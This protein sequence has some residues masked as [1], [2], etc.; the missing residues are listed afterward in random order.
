[1]NAVR[2]AAE[3]YI[4]FGW[5][6]IE[7]VGPLEGG[8]RPRAREWQNQPQV[9]PETW[10]DDSNIGLVTGEASGVVVIDVDGPAG[11]DSLEA[12]QAQIG[13]LPDGPYQ[14]TGSGGAHLLYRYGPECAHLNN[15]GGFRPGLDFRTTG[16]QV[17]LAPSVHASGSAYVMCDLDKELP[18]LPAA[19]IQE[20]S[21]THRT[22]GESGN[23]LTPYQRETMDFA[24]WL[25][26]QPGTITGEAGG[27]EM[28][29]IARVAVR[30]ALLQ[31]AAKFADII[32]GS[33]WNKKKCFPPWTDRWELEKRFH[34]A[35]ARWQADGVVP[36]P[37]DKK[38]HRYKTHMDLRRIVREDPIFA[39][40]LRL[41]ELGG[42]KEYDGQALTDAS[43][44][45][46]RTLIC[47]RYGYGDLDAT[48]VH[49]VVIE[50]CEVNRY[51]PVA[52]Y[53]EGLSWDG[54]PRLNDVAEAILGAPGEL[55]AQMI[56]KWCIGAVARALDPGCDMQAALIFQGAQGIGKSTFFKVMGGEWFSDTPFDVTNKDAFEQI[57]KVWIYEWAELES[58]YR[59]RE[60]TAIKAFISSRSDNFRRAFERI[61][62]EMPRRCVFA[63]STNGRSFLHDRTG[64]RRF[65]IV[66][67]RPVLPGGAN[68]YVDLE[69]LRQ[70]RDQLW[71]EATA[72]Y[73]AGESWALP[74]D[75]D[76]ARA[77][78]AEAF[79]P[80]S[81]VYDRVL[82]LAEKWSDPWV[83]MAEI[84]RRVG[85]TPEMLSPVQLGEIV[86]AVEAAGYRK[87]RKR[88]PDGSGHER[89]YAK[90][91][92]PGST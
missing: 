49:E 79:A 31:D 64:S 7:L 13:Q 4:A 9:P 20:L 63:G 85:V 68:G 34:D 6:V 35:L 50:E 25:E 33:T 74:A 54:V 24:T 12:L 66:E 22:P 53:L 16:G 65:W 89:G 11:Y 37:C 14:I 71:A 52:E 41:N 10:R 3:T 1:M 26:D 21:L 87:M 45:Q 19:W 80:E 67:T 8:K 32:L 88:K 58:M 84:G 90:V 69:T 44:L 92:A 38:G 61:P 82:A 28:M 75:L 51:S 73:K 2:E 15:R 29:R 42:K 77:E 30:K 86:Q 62:V 83:T 72:A 5:R 27:T 36:I 48:R 81:P 78:Q 40:R 47:E 39:G 55:P 46:L 18:T 70:V 60:Q 23:Q 76:T 91:F 43:V 56:R 57:A 17:V 59:S